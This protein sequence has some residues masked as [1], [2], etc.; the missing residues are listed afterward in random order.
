MVEL[1]PGQAADKV[2]RRPAQPTARTSRGKLS[3]RGGCQGGE[4]RLADGTQFL[5][6]VSPILQ[7]HFA[8]QAGDVPGVRLQDVTDDLVQGASAA[9][10]SKAKLL[11]GGSLD[12]TVECLPD[13]FQHLLPALQLT[14]RYR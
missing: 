11:A 12:G 9:T 13:G 6:R 4:H 8:A 2:A 1:V 14:W 7:L 3:A 5:G 10:R